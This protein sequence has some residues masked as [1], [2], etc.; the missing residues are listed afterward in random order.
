MPD[1]IDCALFD[2]SVGELVLELL[3]PAEQAAMLHHASTC[4]R[5]QA[6]LHSL[7]AIA[8]HLAT[9]APECEPPAGFEARVVATF[10]PTHA[11]RRAASTRRRRWTT[12]VLAT[13]AVALLG[14]WLGHTLAGTGDEATTA[15]AGP[16]AGTLMGDGG[17]HGWVVLAP[18][19]DGRA[20]LTMHLSGLPRGT[21]RCLLVA[22]D[23]ASTEVAAWPID[24]SGWG[25]WTVEVAAPGGADHVV[26]IAASGA[27]V[28]TAD[29]LQA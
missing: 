24:D 1:H 15:L 7:S 23:G 13:A 8:D 20:S 6:E 5:C 16:S 26:V 2:E 22:E 10:R 29:L 11:P 4:P 3:E 28:A 12:A 19:D 21:Y 18:T 14:V 17:E 25:Q 27:T 9:A